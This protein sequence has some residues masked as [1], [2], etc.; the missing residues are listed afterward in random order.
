MLSI[1]SQW[2]NHSEDLKDVYLRIVKGNSTL[3]SEIDENF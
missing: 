2:K 3:V 1:F